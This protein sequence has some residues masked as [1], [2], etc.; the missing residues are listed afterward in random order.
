[1][2]ERSGPGIVAIPPEDIV[3]SRGPLDSSLR[4]QFHGRVVAI[5]D[6]GQGR[7]R[8]TADVGTELVACIT[9]A[10]LS[11]LGLNVGDAVVLSVKAMAVRVF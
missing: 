11:E 9:P 10:A 1:V 3:V 6:D 5:R 4:N 2:T 8:L 7:I